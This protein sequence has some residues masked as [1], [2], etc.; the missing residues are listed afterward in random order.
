MLIS[1]INA[2]ILTVILV[3]R[4]EL[5]GSGLKGYKVEFSEKVMY[6]YKKFE[7]YSQP[8]KTDNFEVMW[9]RL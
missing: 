4:Y 6:K 7:I 2:F 3:P 5:K 9:H 1:L 8:S